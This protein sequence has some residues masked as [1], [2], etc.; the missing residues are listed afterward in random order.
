MEKA[1]PGLKGNSINEKENVKGFLEYIKTNGE[2]YTL[3]I[4]NYTTKI[5]SP[6]INKSFLKTM[7]NNAFFAGYSKIKSDVKNKPVPD[8]GSSDVSYFEHNFSKDYFISHAVNIDLKSA[9]STALYNSGV[10]SDSTFLYLSKLKKL[11]RLA[12]VGMMASKKVLFHYDDKGKLKTFERVVNPLQGFFYYCVREVQ[13]IMN[14][15]REIAGSDY[16][17][18]WVDGIYIA[19]GSDKIEDMKMY[20]N[21]IKYPFTVDDLTDFQV[22]FKERKINV[23]FLKGDSK[24]VFNIPAKQNGFTKDFIY[25]LTNLKPKNL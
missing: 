20:L 13:K 18:T 1:K 4:S 3:S 12:T 25:Y 2:P 9:Y 6:S 10:I 19:K 7:R 11:D 15:L 16:L 14:E 17:F 5:T 24:K 8:L 23:S 22:H 21:E